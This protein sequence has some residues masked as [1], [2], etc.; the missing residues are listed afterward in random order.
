MDVCILLY[1]TH[2][3]TYICKIPLAKENNKSNV[4]FIS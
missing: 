3:N 4:D 1:F 2:M